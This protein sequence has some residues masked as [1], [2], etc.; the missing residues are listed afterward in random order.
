M[1]RLSRHLPHKMTVYKNEA[2]DNFIMPL[3]RYPIARPAVDVYPTAD[4][5]LSLRIKVQTAQQFGMIVLPATDRLVI[6]SGVPLRSIVGAMDHKGRNLDL[7]SLTTLV[8]KP[9]SSQ[10]SIA[11]PKGYMLFAFLGSVPCI[12]GA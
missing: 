12:S 6:T 5:V 1:L 4:Q 9:L 10:V 3:D 7:R 2:A 11:L 8:W